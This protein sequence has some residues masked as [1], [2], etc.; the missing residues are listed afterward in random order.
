MHCKIKQHNLQFLNKETE[1][2][3]RKSIK[4]GFIIGL[5]S[6]AL[7]L[8]WIGCGNDTPDNPEVS[9][10]SAPPNDVIEKVKAVQE[11]H[12][13]ELMAIPDVVGTAV[14][15]AEDNTLEV[16]V[17]TKKSDVKGIPASLDGVRIKVA[18]K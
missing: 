12:T 11:K 6:I 13:E 10:S 17:L 9:Y 3:K 5:L 18:V 4:I 7:A 16:V 14:G 15:L 8:F 1:R 2:M